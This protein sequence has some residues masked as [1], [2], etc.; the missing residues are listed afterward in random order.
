NTGTVPCITGGIEPSETGPGV[1]IPARGAHTSCSATP[2]YVAGVHPRRPGAHS[3]F[4]VEEP[5]TCGP[6]P[7][8]QG[9]HSMTWDDAERCPPETIMRSWGFTFS[10]RAPVFGAGALSASRP[11]VLSLLSVSSCGVLR[12]PESLNGAPGCPRPRPP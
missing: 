12:M 4:P 5:P 1:P 9:S 10:L 6:S 7:P 3:H 8:T 11:L 2:G